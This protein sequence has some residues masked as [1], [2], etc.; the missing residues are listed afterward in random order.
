MGMYRQRNPQI[1]VMG[2]TQ[3]LSKAIHEDR[4]LVLN[5]L[6]G[7]TI[8]LPP[9]VGSKARFELRSTVAPTSNSLIFRVANA[10]DVMAGQAQVSLSTGV[11]TI[12]PTV[13]ASDT[14]TAN[15]TTSG[16]A[17]NG[18]FYEFLDIAT[19]LWH[20]FARMNGSGVLVTPFSAAV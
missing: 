4:L 9:A 11:G 6:T 18:E 8:T 15:R 19:N 12:W 1:V 16:G 10:N 2:V 5:S 20:V 3:T 17:S 7:H 13:A 14:I